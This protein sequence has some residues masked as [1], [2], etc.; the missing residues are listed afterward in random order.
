MPQCQ[1][2]Y[3]LA[4]IKN[5]RKLSLRTC[6]NKK[7]YINGNWIHKRTI[8]DVSSDRYPKWKGNILSGSLK[9]DYLH[10][11]VFDDHGKWV[12][13]EK[14]FPNI[15]RLRSVEQCMDGYLY[16]GVETPGKIYRIVPVD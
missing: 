1:G 10:R 14:L 16:F 12:R 6:V 7:K 4:L 2:V 13:E 9:F 15:G 8:I 3:Q 5:T 11:D